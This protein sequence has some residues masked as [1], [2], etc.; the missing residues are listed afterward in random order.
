MPPFDTYWED[1]Q[2]MREY[3]RGTKIGND[4]FKNSVQNALRSGLDAMIREGVT[5]ALI[6]RVSTGIYAGESYTKFVND[7]IN[8]GISYVVS[9]PFRQKVNSEF[10]KWVEEVLSE[11]ISIKDGKDIKKVVRRSMF[12]IIDIPGIKK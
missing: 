9:N 3:I 8:Q 6:A 10:D 1:S 11:D 4:V 7:D 5:I 2:K 12:K